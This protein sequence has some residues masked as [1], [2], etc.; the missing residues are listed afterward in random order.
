VSFFYGFKNCG[1]FG[2]F[3]GAFEVLGSIWEFLRNCVKLGVWS[4]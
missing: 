1:S 4:F 2:G 3:L